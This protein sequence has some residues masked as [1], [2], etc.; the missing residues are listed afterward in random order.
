MQLFPHTGTYHTYK[1][2]D[3]SNGVCHVTKIT[4]TE[5]NPNV[6]LFTQQA[7]CVSPNILSRVMGFLFVC[8]C[9]LL[10]VCVTC[11]CFVKR[12]VVVTVVV[13]IRECMQSYI[14]KMHSV[15]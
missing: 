10:P 9:F 4:T 11:V 6:E 15:G 1:C 8:F 12:C 5:H 13:F 3:F 2:S 7:F 14:D